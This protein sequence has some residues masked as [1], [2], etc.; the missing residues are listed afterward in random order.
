MLGPVFRGPKAGSV[1]DSRALGI[2]AEPVR[3]VCLVGSADERC[4][5]RLHARLVPCRWIRSPLS[6]A[7]GRFV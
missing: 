1:T 3:V 7:G 2:W 6:R 5:V 4:Y